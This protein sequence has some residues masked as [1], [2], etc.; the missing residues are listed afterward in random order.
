MR[1][2]KKWVKVAV[3]KGYE[4]KTLDGAEMDDEMDYIIEPAL[5]EDKTYSTVGAA[6]ET[7]DS[8]TNGV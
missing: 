6:F 1:E 7:I 2:V 4:V 8:H 5:E 3:H